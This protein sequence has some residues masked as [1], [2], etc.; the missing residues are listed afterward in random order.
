MAVSGCPPAVAA[1][2]AECA[3]RELEHELL[4]RLE[5]HEPVG[6][7]YQ[8]PADSAAV[9]EVA[10]VVARGLARG[11][12]PAGRAEDGRRRAPRPCAA[13][14]GVAAVCRGRGGGE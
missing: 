10:R 5:H 12:R 7:P 14:G 6:W 13:A 2:A 3:R 9:P 1:R 11:V 8:R 4:P